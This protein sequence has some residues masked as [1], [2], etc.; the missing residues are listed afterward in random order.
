MTRRLIWFLICAAAGVLLVL[1]GLV[2]PAHLR[3]VDASVLRAASKD[4]P[5]LVEQGRALLNQ[6]KLGAA[7]L[8][9]QAARAAGA[10]GWQ[11][12]DAAINQVSA[13]HPKWLVWGGGDAR[14]E[15]LFASDP[16]LPQSRSE[17][18]TDFLVREQNRAVVL[19]LL[20]GSSLPAVQ[21]LLRCRTLTNTVIFGGTLPALTRF[22][23]NAD[24]LVYDAAR[25]LLW[26]STERLA[27]RREHW[28]SR[29]KTLTE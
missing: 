26:R 21:E 6:N 15:R 1:G 16:A 12:L 13:Q 4:T 18:F 29:S 7:Q 20:Q 19:E 5:T 28:D 14:L 2:L 9:L 10:A 23:L 17:P 25:D 27:S 11:G 22:W 3:A 8:I 24:D